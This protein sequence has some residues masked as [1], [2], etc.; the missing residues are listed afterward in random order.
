MSGELTKNYILVLTK[1]IEL[2]YNNKRAEKKHIPHKKVY[3][4]EGGEC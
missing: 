1:S 3:L 4:P 2:R